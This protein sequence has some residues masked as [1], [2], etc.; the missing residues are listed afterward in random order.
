MN[1]MLGFVAVVVFQTCETVSVGYCLFPWKRFH[2]FYP[3]SENPLQI[4]IA[5][6]D[7]RR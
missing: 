7:I 3:V 4:F 2:I 6:F 1:Y 5:F